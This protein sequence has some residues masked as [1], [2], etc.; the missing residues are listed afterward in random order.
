MMVGEAPLEPAMA[1]IGAE[2]VSVE[3][4]EVVLALAI[5]ERHLDHTGHVH[6]GIIAALTDTAAGYAVHTQVPAGVR[7]ASVE[8]HVGITAPAPLSAGRILIVG[9]TIRIGARTANCEAKVVGAN[10]AL[11]AA[12]TMTM[13]VLPSPAA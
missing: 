12:M 8:F 7:C 11:H 5:G 4:G 2:I 10:G 13:I 6:N 3:Q 9:R 1:L